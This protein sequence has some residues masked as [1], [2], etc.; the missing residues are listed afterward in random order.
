[1]RVIA[2]P[3]AKGIEALSTR[4]HRACVYAAPPGS[5]RHFDA[6]LPAATAFLSPLKD[7]AASSLSAVLPVTT[8]ASQP[9]SLPI[10]TAWA[11]STASASWSPE[12]AGLVGPAKLRRGR[13]RLE[14]GQIPPIKRFV[15]RSNSSPIEVGHHA[16]Q[17]TTAT[18][19]I[20]VFPW[21]SPRWARGRGP[22]GRSASLQP[23]SVPVTPKSCL[24]RGDIHDSPAWRRARRCGERMI[25]AD[26]N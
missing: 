14:C 12:H 11:Q 2:A 7:L 5:A 4:P 26:E 22:P 15:K 17:V 8:R 19:D 25:L 13:P 24:R 18:A 23:A 10:T 9:R 1:M 16:V 3:Q 6:S 20:G 21:L